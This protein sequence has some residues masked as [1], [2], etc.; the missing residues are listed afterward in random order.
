[1]GKV[2][3][4]AWRPD[5]ETLAAVSG[6]TLQFF[7]ART[8][9]PET[10]TV[11]LSGDQSATFGP[12]GELLKGDPDAIERELVYMVEQ[13]DGRIELLAPSAFHK[14]VNQAANDR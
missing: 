3:V 1:M 11:F 5:G 14:R 8:F 10:S 13:P 9:A 4:V 2:D 6:G 7:N 12:G